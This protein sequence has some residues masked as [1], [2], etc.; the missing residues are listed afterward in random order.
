MATVKAMR[1]R[2]TK[3]VRSQPY[4]ISHHEL[5]E[6]DYADELRDS[7]DIEAEESVG[8]S[9]GQS[10][11][12]PSHKEKMCVLKHEESDDPDDKPQHPLASSMW[13][14]DSEPYDAQ[15]VASRMKRTSETYSEGDMRFIYLMAGSAMVPVETLLIQV[16][17]GEIEKRARTAAD[18]EIQ[19]QI[20]DAERTI[21]FLQN[22]LMSLNAEEAA[23]L[24]D[25]TASIAETN[26]AAELIKIDTELKSVKTKKE[27]FFD[28]VHELAR[29]WYYEV[30][31]QKKKTELQQRH[32]DFIESRPYTAKLQELFAIVNMYAIGAT[33]I[34]DQ[35][36]YAELSRNFEITDLIKILFGY[37]R[38]QP[39]P[40]IIARI[41][42]TETELQQLVLRGLP[43][44]D[45]LATQVYLALSKQQNL[46]QDRK[47]N[48]KNLYNRLRNAKPVRVQ[49]QEVEGE[50]DDAK[51]H[52][53]SLQ[54]R[55]VTLA[56]QP[57]PGWLSQPQN[58]PSQVQPQLTP[59]ATAAINSSADL[60]RSY[61]TDH[62]ITPPTLQSLM[63]TD[64]VMVKFAELA[65]K[66]Y[67]KNEAMAGSRYTQRERLPM[68]TA[69][70][71]RTYA[72]L[73]CGAKVDTYGNISMIDERPLRVIPF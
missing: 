5:R 63:N 7:S 61:F 43:P 27:R 23:A 36:I 56:E 14:V 20:A 40:V 11:L 30:Y 31:W 66:F 58:L 35:P 60:V 33:A 8:L 16:S 62:G 71:E 18:Q 28:L 4:A 24:N 25:P 32:K 65:G 53:D 64:S 2:H 22:R 51:N 15:W 55:R 41:P 19:R 12:E 3:H 29:A 17:S 38:D 42:K 9:M 46:L 68:L 70:I 49:I 45:S 1:S 67:L 54:A 26:A 44:D 10:T 34:I 6:T 39:D 48:A 69:D 50:L 57:G 21:T 72:S 52:L 59:S 73:T 47:T 37:P 13:N